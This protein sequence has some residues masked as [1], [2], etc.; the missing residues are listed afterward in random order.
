[1]ARREGSGW[2]RTWGS[3]ATLAFALHLGAALYEL[4]VV[5]PLWSV[6]LPKSAAAWAAMNARP[7]SSR[8]FTP[9]L[10]AVVFSTA[11]AWISG[12]STR[13]WRRGWLTLALVAAAASAEIAW[14]QLLPVE[15]ELF[16]PAA[17]GEG[18]GA[19]VIG[20]AGDWLRWSG[21]RMAALLAGAYFAWSAQLSGGLAAF[22]GS[23]ESAP[24]AG[25]EGRRPRRRSRDFSL[26][27]LDEPEVTFGD[28][29][30]NA[31]EQWRR[32]LPPRRRTAKK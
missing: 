32:S 18:N 9:L 25:P 10:L 15:R 26:G 1:M 12:L 17:L 29:A 23:P 21:A 2:S 13:G 7:D 28:E 24:D 11:M 30:P 5:F 19:V 4:V 27:D 6:D 3:V 8:V 16:G 14:M 22:A 31:R 20:L